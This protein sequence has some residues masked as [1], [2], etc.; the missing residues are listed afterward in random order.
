MRDR[1]SPRLLKILVAGLLVAVGT[2]A[3]LVPAG[4][5]TCGPV[6]FVDADQAGLDDGMTWGTAFPDLQDGL[7][8]AALC[9]GV[10][11]AIWIA[12]GTYHPHATDNTVSFEPVDDVEMIGGFDGTE[13]TLNQRP[14]PPVAAILSGDLN[15]DDSVAGISEN[16]Q[17]VVALPLDVDAAL[18]DL[19]ISD[20][21]ASGTFPQGA[22]ILA[23]PRAGI[24]PTLVLDG[25]II[26]DN[27]ADLSGGA[28]QF[29]GSSFRMENSLVSQNRTDGGGSVQLRAASASDPRFVI[30]DS[31]F[32][33]NDS[34]VAGA[35][36]VDTSTGVDI[37][38]TS[39]SRNTSV[40]GGGAIVSS[41]DVTVLRS[42]FSRN[43]AGR[44]GGAITASTL[45]RLEVRNSL[46]EDNTSTHSL[47]RGGAINVTGSATLFVDGST[48]SGNESGKHQG[49]AIASS[50]A[51]AEV[52]NSVFWDNSTGPPLYET[53][54]VRNSIVQHSGGSGP[55]WDASS[56]GVDAG[57]NLDSDPLFVLNT[58]FELSASS[59]AID[60]GDAGFLALDSLDSDNDGNTSEFLPDLN[61]D[62]R[63]QGSSNDMGAQ[64]FA[65]FSTELFTTLSEPC[66]LYASA[67]ASGSLDGPIEGNEVRQ[68]RST[69]IPPASQGGS[70]TQCVPAG[71][72]AVMFQVSVE[73]PLAA[74]NLQLSES[75]VPPKGGVVN[76]AANGLDNANTLTV[77]I[78]ANG[79]VDLAANGGPSGVGVALAEVRLLAIGYHSPASTQQFTP[80]TPCAVADSRLTQSAEF[81]FRGPFTSGG[82]AYPAIDVV[83]SFNPDQGGG[84]SDCG[85][86]ASAESV[87][88]NLIATNST[89]AAGQ[90][91]IGPEG[92]NPSVG[93]TPFAP[94][95][96]NNASVAVVPLNSE[97]VQVRVLGPAAA[98]TNIRLVVIGYMSAMGSEF[99]AVNSCAAFDTRASQGGSGAFGGTRNGGDTTTYQI[100]GSL[101][102]TQGGLNLGS[103]GVPPGA[104]GVMIN[105]VAV[106]PVAAGN[107]QAFAAGSSPSGGLLNYRDLSPAMNNSN[108]VSV[109]LSNDGKMSVFVNGG[110][111]MAPGTDIRG[112]IVGYYLG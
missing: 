61:N 88:L 12:E 82:T 26:E 25:V 30:R 2:P 110:G 71:A 99:R 55:G 95:G 96:M 53:S 107:L 64:E 32:L 68:I 65:N 67:S 50:S 94:I 52:V 66:L 54:W 47:L 43:V 63:L 97:K 18:T 92:S 75:G 40:F 16:S 23:Q 48:F 34:D 112:V 78:N 1:R 22:A 4:A 98:S 49:E 101:D 87:V 86:P 74:G 104:T 41:G 56:F 37:V 20:G 69:G 100:S 72:S 8:A 83:G 7:A 79:D 84:Q 62:Q 111:S 44:G 57:G 28:I 73:S 38:D 45:G 59:P 15:D 58:N 85:V 21:N 89:G 102:A 77:P 10:T 29:F 46:F 93:G 36:F 108:A 19:V 14:F 80:L 91:S 17:H 51:T 106:N 5:M 105:L 81:P 33:D 27:D 90:L 103:C 9:P 31:L 13:S 39:F 70:A 60:T 24:P 11:T 35:L 42:T 3:M 6:V 109:P 76:F